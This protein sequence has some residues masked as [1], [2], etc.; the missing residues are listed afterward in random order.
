MALVEKTVL[1]AHSAEQMF[2]LVD[3]VEE[4]PQFLPWC[5][6]ASV[7]EQD[8]TT[9]HATVHIDYHHLKQ[10]FTTENV[11]TPPYRIEMTLLDGPFQHLDGS[12]QFIPLSDEACKI[13]FRLHYEF[14]SKLLE[15]LVGPVFHFIANSFVDAFIHRAEKIYTDL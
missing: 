7:V 14:S 15:K 3:R 11:R 10:H 4:Y 9:V 2:N 13:E 1:V 8:G 12:W 6:G 5:G